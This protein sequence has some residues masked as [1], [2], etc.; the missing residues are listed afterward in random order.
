M[1]GRNKGF[2]SFVAKINPQVKIV[3]CMIHR[4][5]L[6]SEFL[7]KEL[8]ETMNEVVKIVNYIK[9][10]PLRTRVFKLLC[11]KMDFDHKNLLHHT[12][13]R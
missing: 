1:Q 8:L 5:V 12:E 10:N 3:H 4:E 6:V 9:S 13:I 11:E 2:V 7:P